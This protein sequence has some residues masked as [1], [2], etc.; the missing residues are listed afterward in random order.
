MTLT[1]GLRPSAISRPVPEPCGAVR[2][3]GRREDASSASSA[4]T[5]GRDDRGNWKIARTDRNAAV[6]YVEKLKSQR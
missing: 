4:R 3:E 5:F 6:R 1:Q 2:H